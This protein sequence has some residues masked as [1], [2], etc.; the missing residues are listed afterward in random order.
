MNTGTSN[1][2]AV[3]TFFKSL[4]FS[5]AGIAAILGNWQVESSL[6]PGASNPNEGAIGVAQWE[7]SRRTALQEF[8][9]Q[10][11]TSETDLATQLAFAQHEL[12]SSGIYN[13]MRNATDPGSA[14]A[15][16]DA[17]YERSAGT[18]RGQR[19]TD[20]E[21][22]YTAIQ[23]GNL[24]T[25]QGFTASS[26]VDPDTGLLSWQAIGAPYDPAALTKQKSVTAAQVA[27]IDAWLKKAVTDNKLPAQYA[28][29]PDPHTDFGGYL[30]NYSYTV[31]L[32]QQ[33]KTGPFKRNGPL[34]WTDQL[35]GILQWVTTIKNWERIG[36]FVLGAVI[37]LVAAVE[38][39][40]GPGTTRKAVETVGM[41]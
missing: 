27:K 32:V 14:A 9:R 11:G 12:Q 25:V 20:A 30:R 24:N 16:W 35:S 28:T 26:N 21:K 10:R 34:A 1:A 4:G 3:Y 39:V 13:V 2:D 29:P 22:Y 19:V 8:A 18:T 7:G 33:Q 40:G 23:S 15:Y 36:L 38:F 41:V 17:N 5:D 31:W 37:L 6:N